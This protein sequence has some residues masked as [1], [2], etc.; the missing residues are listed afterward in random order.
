TDRLFPLTRLRRCN[1]PVLEAGSSSLRQGPPPRGSIETDPRM[2][3]QSIKSSSI[4][5]PERKSRYLHKARTEFHLAVINLENTVEKELAGDLN[6][7]L[8]EYAA[9]VDHGKNLAYALSQAQKT[10]E[11]MIAYLKRVSPEP[12]YATALKNADYNAMHERLL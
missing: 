12:D 5:S 9:A 8:K 6:A 7:S 4:S 3:W 1:L 10:H 11:E 2:L